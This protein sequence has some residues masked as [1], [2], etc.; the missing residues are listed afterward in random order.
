MT[1]RGRGTEPSPFI[2]GW[3]I[4]AGPSQLWSSPELGEACHNASTVQHFPLPIPISVIITL[5][6][7]GLENTP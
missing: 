2:S 3:D 7:D 6:R 4:S 1:G 5:P